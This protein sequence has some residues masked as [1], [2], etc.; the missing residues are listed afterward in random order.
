MLL[1][2]RPH[3]RDERTTAFDRL[4]FG[5]AAATSPNLAKSTGVPG[6]LL[7]NCRPPKCKNPTS[8]HEVHQ[9][10]DQRSRRST[11]LW[12]DPEHQRDLSKVY[13]L[14]PELGINAISADVTEFVVPVET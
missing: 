5:A 13:A 1:K 7:G 11:R 6:A 4:V 2:Q 12:Q 9:R 10:E 3:L 8:A 14:P